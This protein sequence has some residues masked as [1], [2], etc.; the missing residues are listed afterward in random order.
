VSVILKLIKLSWQIKRS[1][2][3]NMANNGGNRIIAIRVKLI[4]RQQITRH[5]KHLWHSVFTVEL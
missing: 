3:I 1:S 2:N 4:R 5:D